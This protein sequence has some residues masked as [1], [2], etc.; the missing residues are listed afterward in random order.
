[1]ETKHLAP[2]LTGTYI[3]AVS[4]GID[5]VV[6]LDMLAGRPELELIVAH[7]DH[8][9]RENS[10]DDERFV[11]GLAEKYQLKYESRR[12]E[13]GADASEATA[14]DARYS[15]LKEVQQKYQA[16]GIITAHHQDD[17]LETS[18]IN[19][20][21][22]TGRRGLHSLKNHETLLRPLLHLTKKEL[23]RYAEEHDIQWREDSTNAETHYLRNK[24]RQHVIPK[25]DDEW[26]R[27]MLNHIAKAGEINEKLDREID[28]L[29]SH[30]LA[31]RHAALSRRWFV[32]L[33][34]AV[35]S[36]VV[37]A[38]LRRLHT[39]NIDHNLVERLT[40]GIKTAK[41]GKKLDIDKD[42]YILITKRSARVMDHISGKSARV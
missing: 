42:N 9:I 20:L 2:H 23:Y 41:P 13:L 31:F 16:K 27:R 17:L 33:P 39:R 15:F 4:G 38:L 29:L 8:G 5:S 7:F 28:A 12:A 14:R 26:R 37:V 3:L 32:M 19:L 24:I 35:A 1:M 25:A 36:E 6:L 34:H 18:V 21:R 10:A 40:I 30:K 11:R 22:G